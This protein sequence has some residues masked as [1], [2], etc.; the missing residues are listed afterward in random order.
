[1]PRHH[2]FSAHFLGFRTSFFTMATTGGTNDAGLLQAL[3]EIIQK[4]EASL[5]PKIKEN[6]KKG[7]DFL[8]TKNSLLLS[9]LIDLVVLLKSKLQGK[10]P[11]N[12]KRLTEMKVALDKI[13]GLDKKLR[14]QIDK[15][16]AAAS[17]ASVFAES[18]EDPL[19]FRPNAEALDD[20]DDSDESSSSNSNSEV[21]SDGS[22]S[23]TR[24]Q[25]D[26]RKNKK[27]DY[28]FTASAADE[29]DDL[30]AA[31]LTISMAKQKSKNN[32]TDDTA[33]DG[34]YRAPRLTA[35]P[36]THDTVDK[37]EQRQSRLRRRMRA[38]EVAQTLR[39]QY[40]DAPEQDDAHGGIMGAQQEAARRFA[41]RQADKLKFEE[42]TMVRLVESR[43]DKKLRKSIQR[44]EQSNLGAIS[45]LG[46]IVR[47]AAYG[48]D[49]DRD[50]SR[51]DDDSLGTER[52]ANGKRKRLQV[53]KD[54]RAVKDRS[55]HTFKSK[56]SLQS[57]LYGSG[58]SAGKKGKKKSR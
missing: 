41:E 22:D 19:Q 50:K 49:K 51:I 29:D 42:D 8:E 37:E 35:V 45:D 7:L 52:H 55:K 6:N 40:G 31:R 57:A 9:Y 1:M 21:D 17:S 14:Y 10:D 12:L 11:P 20:D 32:N 28:T 23:D 18:G 44:Q 54:G 33:N 13:R 47:G 30:A 25:P 46:N 48:R 2:L 27:D 53:D 4:V 56:N 5:K 39:N 36:Y 3:T 58:N 38:T 16:L 24:G 26:R 34:I 43:K 15:L